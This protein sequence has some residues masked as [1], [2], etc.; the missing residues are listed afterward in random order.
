ML[1]EITDAILV[2]R[3][4]GR[5]TCPSCGAMFH[6]DAIR[7]RL[8]GVCDNCGTDLVQRDDDREEVIRKRLQVYH[9][10]TAPLIEF[11]RKSHQLIVIDASRSAV[12][13]SSELTLRLSTGSE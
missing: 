12:Q 11:Y 6:I 2:S 5:R 13:V 4:T 1:F 7:P 3:L 10:Q 8:D 9:D